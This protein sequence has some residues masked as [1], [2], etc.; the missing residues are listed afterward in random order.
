M[1]LVAADFSFPLRRR[2][3]YHPALHCLPGPGVQRALLA[4][5]EWL[6][7]ER[8]C[9]LVY[10]RVARGTG[11]GTRRH[12]GQPEQTRHQRRRLVPRPP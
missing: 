11:C 10:S 8:Q 12:P 3:A 2:I 1:P 9:G 6:V 5:G 4:A 7:L